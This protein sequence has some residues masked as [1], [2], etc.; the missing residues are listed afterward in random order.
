MHDKI[1]KMENKEADLMCKQKIFNNLFK[2]F[3]N[4]LEV[5]H[6]NL[7]N[8]KMELKSKNLLNKMKSKSKQMFKMNKI[9]NYK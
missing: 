3:K 8:L 6:F 4:K 5:N 1:I 9:M 2:I 7:S